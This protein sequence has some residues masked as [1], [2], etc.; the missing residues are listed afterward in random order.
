MELPGKEG[1]RTTASITGTII[2]D[3]FK[4]HPNI[5][6]TLFDLLNFLNASIMQK[7]AAIKRVLQHTFKDTYGYSKIIQDK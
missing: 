1:N 7:K 4:E 2:T 5:M 6:L 3:L